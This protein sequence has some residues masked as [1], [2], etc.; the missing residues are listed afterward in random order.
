[1]DKKR[2][3]KVMA[4][5]AEVFSK[6]PISKEKTDIYYR[7]L[8]NYPIES[9]ESAAD[10]LIEHKTIPT[11][12]LPAEIIELCTQRT[13]TDLELQA[14]SAWAKARRTASA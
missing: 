2:F 9:I 5:L 4:T 12:P 8:C 6:D 10:Y 14:S 11:F 13:K 1:M 3:A 7:V